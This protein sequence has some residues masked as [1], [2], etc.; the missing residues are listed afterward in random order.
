MG[1]N[2]RRIF[3][4]LHSTR[5]R[6]FKF[7][8]TIHY[9]TVRGDVGEKALGRLAEELR[10]ELLSLSHVSDVNIGGSRN[11]EVTIEVSEEKLFADSAAATRLALLGSRSGNARSDTRGQK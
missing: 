11:E 2:S 9:L 10:D 3:S 8:E 5:I 4:R 6:T 7:K 1:A